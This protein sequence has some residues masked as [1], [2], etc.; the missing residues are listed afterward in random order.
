MRLAPGNEYFIIS[1]SSEWIRCCRFRKKGA[2]FR[3]L[4]HASAPILSDG[5]SSRSDALRRVLKETGCGTDSRVILTGALPGGMFFRC[6]GVSMP[7]KDQRNA[8]EF[9]LPQK[10]LRIPPDCRIQFL[11]LET[12]DTLPGDEIEMNVYAFPGSAMDGL[13]ALLAQSRCKADE[14]LYPLIALE[15]G[16]PPVLLPELEKD[17]C[18]GGGQWKVPPTG[19]KEMTEAWKKKFSSCLQLP[20]GFR[21]EEYLACLLVMRALQSPALKRNEGGVRVLPAALRPSRYRFHLF[22]TIV[23]LVLIAG[24]AVHD[25]AGTCMKRYEE[26]RDLAAERNR[27][28]RKTSELKAK[29][30]NSEKEWKELGRVT[31]L[32]AGESNLL[33]TLADLTEV[34]PPDVL[35]TSLRLNESTLSLTLQTESETLNLPQTLRRLSRWK[36]GQLQQRRM[37]DTVQMITLTLIPSEA[38]E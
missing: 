32:K 38:S 8:V 3:L 13:A 14:F 19:R 23:L 34:L 17:F 18:F 2:Y 10:M 16:D 12:P 20:E 22:I 15:A 9:E 27:F 30:K 24:V 5:A 31:K 29:R 35:V 6:S 1:I 26:Y 33:G 21:E 7:L 25:L 36:I 4:A 37:D 28:Q 11:P